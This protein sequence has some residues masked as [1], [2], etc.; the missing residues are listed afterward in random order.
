MLPI[1]AINDYLTA[2]LMCGIINYRVKEEPF[3][4]STLLSLEKKFKI[5]QATR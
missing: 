4:K 5:G 1:V 3:Q 2:L